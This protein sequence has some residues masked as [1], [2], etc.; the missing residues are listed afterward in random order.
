MGIVI[1]CLTLTKLG[2]YYG[3]R[4]L[5]LVGLAMN[6]VLVSLLMLSE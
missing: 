3:R 5:F 2:D 1:G 6:F 4:P